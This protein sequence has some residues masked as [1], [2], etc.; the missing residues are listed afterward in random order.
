MPPPPD[1]SVARAQQKPE[2]GVE[3][4]RALAGTL[5]VTVGQVAQ[6]L[7]P[8]FAGIDAG[9]WVDPLG[10]TRDATVRLVPEARASVA[11]LESLLL[12]IPTVYDSMGEWRERGGHARTR[13]LDR[14]G[15]DD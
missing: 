1:G 11:D 14:G 8:A 9:D 7:R 12:V 13:R 6:S 15:H 10:K 2:I 4:D 5:G 3:L